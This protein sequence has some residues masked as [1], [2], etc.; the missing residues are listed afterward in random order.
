ME[1]EFKPS[2]KQYVAWEYLTDNVTREIG[3]GGGAGGGKSYLGCVWLTSMCL[4]YPETG[5]LLGRK[6]LVTL[7]RTT[8]LTLFKV[9]SDFGIGEE[10]YTYNQQNNTIVFNNG[11]TIFLMDL[12]YK[13]SDPLYTRFGGLELT[14]YF[15]DES[16]ECPEE[17]VSIIKTRT[18]R[19]LNKEF[20]LTPKGLET[21]NPDKGHVYRRFYKPYKEK[22]SPEHIKFIPAL[23]TDNEYIDEAYIEQLRNADNT[24]RERL[25]YGNF[26]YDDNPDLMIPYDVIEDL[27]TNT[28]SGGVNF[29]TAD[30]ARHGKDKTVIYRWNGLRLMEAKVIDNSS[31][32]YVK[33]EIKEIARLHR[34]PYSRIIVD[35]DG[36]GG[37][38]VDM[39]KGIRGFMANRRPF[40]VVDLGKEVPANYQ[41]LKTQC[42]Y[43]LAEMINLHL[44]SVE[45]EKIREP[46]TEELAVLQRTDVDKENKLKVIPKE[47]MKEKLGRSPDFLDAMYMR[48][49]FELKHI[50]ST[51]SI[52]IATPDE[53]KNS[54]F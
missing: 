41:N 42:I 37:G 46:L 31:L 17:A 23:A 54:A 20:D 7:K 10:A 52:N 45:D 25:L 16:N 38:I 22:T 34:V 8:L 30:I 53:F 33:E 29:I 18:G 1:V 21:F 28:A 32:D 39:M 48:M 36:V 14:G 12:G 26:D 27:W 5:W 6:E 19:R 9:F 51:P 50:D 15:I 49:W 13:P 43:K 35:E 11:S 44:L 4:A 24:T 2:K 47:R 3:Y 40:P